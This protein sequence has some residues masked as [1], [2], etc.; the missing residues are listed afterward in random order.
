MFIVDSA[1]YQQSIASR[2]NS[3]MS[4]NFHASFQ[5][6]MKDLRHKINILAQNCSV[7]VW[8]L[9]LNC[10]PDKSLIEDLIN[11]VSY[12]KHQMN[13][14]QMKLSVAYLQVNQDDESKEISKL[15]NLFDQSIDNFIE[16]QVKNLMDQ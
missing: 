15:I 16:H 13:Q 14:K 12:I 4:M 1:D 10:P 11:E 9:F 8:M 5:D 6:N 3:E 2:N 7:P